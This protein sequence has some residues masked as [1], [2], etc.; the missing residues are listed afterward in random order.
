MEGKMSV[1]VTTK[2][3]APADEPVPTT[4]KRIVAGRSRRKKAAEV[5][6]QSEQVA[7]DSERAAAFVAAQHGETTV[8]QAAQAEQAP[9]AEA[10]PAEETVT[11]KLH[12]FH[13]Y[14]VGKLRP[15]ATSEKWL[16]LRRAVRFDL[17]AGEAVL[18]KAM[19]EKQ[20]LIAG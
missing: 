8:G 2:S 11:I 7:T 12:D 3:A 17:Q 5:T 10:P 13:L 20:K 1:T 14:L 15:D 6:P 18:P 9:S 19:A 4:L 16:D